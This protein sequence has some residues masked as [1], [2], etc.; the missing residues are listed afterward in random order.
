M[1]LFKRTI[2]VLL[3]IGVV[4]AFIMSFSFILISI[5]CTGGVALVIWVPVLFSLGLLLKFIIRVCF[6]QPGD[7]N[8]KNIVDGRQNKIIATP[9]E[10][11]AI[12]GYIVS[13]RNAGVMDDSM[14]KS[15]LKYNG[16]WSDKEIEQAFISCSNTK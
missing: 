5:I 4:L 6:R 2:G 3:I 13:S 11:L 9:N 1:K 14:I 16:G 12:I 10:E 15:K 7:I 8:E